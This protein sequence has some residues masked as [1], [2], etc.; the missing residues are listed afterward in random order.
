MWCPSFWPSDMCDWIGVPNFKHWKAAEYTGE[1][2]LT[3]VL[4]KAIENRLAK[5][6]LDP[7]DHIK[8]NVDKNKQKRKKGTAFRS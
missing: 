4:R 1:G 8:I 2:G 5:K 6:H 7:S 3:A